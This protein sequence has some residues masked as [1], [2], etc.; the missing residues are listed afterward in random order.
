MSEKPISAPYLEQS[1][2]LLLQQRERFL[3]PLKAVLLTPLD[4]LGKPIPVPG[5]GI[6][7]ATG[8]IRMEQDTPHLYACWHT[9]TGLNRN[10]RA[11]PS[12]P[13][14]RPFKLRMTLQEYERQQLIEK[15]GG[16][17]DFVVD[18]YRPDG[19]T[20]AWMQDRQYVHNEDVE[21]YG[22][23]FPFWHDAVK[24][25]LSGIDL[26]PGQLINEP[27]VC[28]N[29]LLPTDRVFI[30]GYP[31]GYSVLDNPT[32]V[33]LTAHIAALRVKTNRHEFL[34]DR[35]GAPGMS[36]SPVFLEDASGLRL[37]GLYTGVIG[38]VNT[39][40]VSLGACADMRLCWGADALALVPFDSQTTQALDADGYPLPSSAFPDNESKG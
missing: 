20:P 19:A 1:A 9:V 18:L 32:P 31:N 33:V 2:N 15:I 10:T 11:I 37:I 8:F 29:M 34:V 12:T 5:G 17:R 24:L 6:K 39:L 4:Q 27:Q 13:P 26:A 16:S 21:R 28:S 22:L 14:N 40:G 25:Q 30:V 38:S 36:G 23:R 7:K 35:A 3:L